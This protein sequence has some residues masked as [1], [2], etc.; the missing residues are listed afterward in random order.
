MEIKIYNERELSG[1]LIN[2]NRSL[3]KDYFVLEMQGGGKDYT[4]LYLNIYQTKEVRDM[5]SA[6]IESYE[7]ENIED[8]YIKQS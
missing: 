5:L 7:K 2:F 1:A 4:D 6:Y 3:N 8:E